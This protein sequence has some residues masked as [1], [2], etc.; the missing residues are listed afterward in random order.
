MRKPRSV[1]AVAV[2]LASLAGLAAPSPAAA[3][4]VEERVVVRATII[5][6]IAAQFRGT[7]RV[8][9]FIG[10]GGSYGAPVYGNLDEQTSTIELC[11]AS[12]GCGST[13]DLLCLAVAPDA[14]LRTEDDDSGTARADLSGCAVTLSFRALGEPTPILRIGTIPE[15]GYRRSGVADSA[16]LGGVPAGFRDLTISRT[17]LVG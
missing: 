12:R 1:V 16:T 17:R 6:P 13:K 15:I 7:L 2:S 9:R 8:R 3:A 14:V 10:I 4:S 5:S 11:E